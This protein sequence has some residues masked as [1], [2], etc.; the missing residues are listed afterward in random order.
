LVA[1]E[2]MAEGLIE[3]GLPEMV[4]R[5]DQPIRPDVLAG[6][7]EFPGSFLAKQQP[8]PEGGHRQQRRAVQHAGQ[9]PGVVTVPDRLRGNRVD[10][11]GQDG[12][13]HGAQVD[14]EQVV[15]ADPGQPL[16]AG[17]ETAA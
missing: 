16:P 10:R 14:I 2:Q 7:G 3:V 12:I 11:P 9:R 6:L 1:A 17:A 8:R 4:V 5:L 13:G 15:E